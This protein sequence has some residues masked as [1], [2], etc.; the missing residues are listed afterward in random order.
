MKKVLGIPNGSLEKAT[1][2]LLERVGIKINVKGRRFESAILQSSIFDRAII[3]RPQD[4]PGAV[5]DGMIDVGITGLDQVCESGRKENLKIITE[6]EYSKKSKSPVRVVAFARENNFID[7]E[8]I[9]VA[10]EYPFLTEQFFKKAAIRFSH[11]G[12]EQKVAYGKYDYGV[13]ITETGESLRKN[14]LVIVKTLL[15]SPTVLIAKNKTPELEYFGELMAGGLRAEK[16]NLLKM[17]VKEEAKISVL[18]ILPAIMAPTVNRLSSGDYAIETVILKNEVSNLI[19]ALKA[20]G[21]SGILVSDIAI[22]I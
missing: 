22:V 9:L 4:I 21:G 2:D 11:G 12:T 17:N 15:I 13:C 10:S 18:K 3:M 1:L 7:A 6:L 20:A 19:I 5:I 14:G 8:G 16:Y